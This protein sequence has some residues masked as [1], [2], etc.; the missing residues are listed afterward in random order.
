M[1]Q[2]DKGILVSNTKSKWVKSYGKMIALSLTFCLTQYIHSASADT[3]ETINSSLS[4]QDSNTWSVLKKDLRVRTF[5]EVMSPPL[6]GSQTSVPLPNGQ[7]YAPANMFH[8]AWMD[9]P[10]A[11]NLRVVYW[12]RML[13]FLSSNSDPAFRKSFQFI[14]RDPRFALRWTDV[15]NIPQLSTT[16]D[17]Y[18]Q[19]GVTHNVLSTGDRYDIGFRTNTAYSIPKSRWSI[20]LVQEFNFGGLDPKGTGPRTCCWFMPWASYDINPKFST[21]HVMYYGIKNSRKNK[22][23]HYEWDDAGMPY[24]QNGVGLNVSQTVQLA[25]F[26]NNYLGTKPTLKNTWTSLWVSINLL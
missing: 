21:Q 13:M 7:D 1:K 18:I 8:I 20:G 3:G 15:F 9:Y 26:V 16:Y 25:A 4:H 6:L 2:K 12:Q 23:H 14:P 10:I 19:P 17:L 24:I 22:L 11:K 5:T